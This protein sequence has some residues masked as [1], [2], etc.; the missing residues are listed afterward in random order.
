MHLEHGGCY[1]NIKMKRRFERTM[2]K[3][4]RERRSKSKQQIRT[5]SSGK[6]QLEKKNAKEKKKERKR[7]V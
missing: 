1:T 7:R 3:P 6:Y 4:A 5:F 2:R